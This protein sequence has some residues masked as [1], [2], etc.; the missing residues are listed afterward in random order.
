LINIKINHSDCLKYCL[1]RCA[2]IVV[3]V[4][5]EMMAFCLV[6]WKFGKYLPECNSPKIVTTL[7]LKIDTRSCKDLYKICNCDTLI[8]VNG[9]CQSFKLW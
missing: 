2:H 6:P 4:H 7:K 3:L 5:V 8:D 1:S 9:R